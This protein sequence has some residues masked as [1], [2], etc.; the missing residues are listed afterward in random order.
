VTSTSPIARKGDNGRNPPTK[1]FMFCS[2]ERNNN[3]VS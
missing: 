2:L 3:A 1:E